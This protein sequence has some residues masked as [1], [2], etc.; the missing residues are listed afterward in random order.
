MWGRWQEHTESR[1]LG[2]HERQRFGGCYAPTPASWE[3]AAPVARDTALCLSGAIERVSH[4]T[5]EVHQVVQVELRAVRPAVARV[6]GVTT[7][8]GCR[9]RNA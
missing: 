4:I 9:E 6:A 7:C 2:E 1:T 5:R 3:R 8:D